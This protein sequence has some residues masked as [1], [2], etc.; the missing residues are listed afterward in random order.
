MGQQEAFE[1][2]YMEQCVTFKNGRFHVTYPYL[3]DP[4]LLPYNYNQVVRIA[5]RE[6]T[7]L[8]R[9]GWMEEWSCGT[10]AISR[11]SPSRK[12]RRGRARLTM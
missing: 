12:K 8:E 1:F 10:K 4:A 5:E 11:S 9:D 7:L 6:E 2:E 3:V